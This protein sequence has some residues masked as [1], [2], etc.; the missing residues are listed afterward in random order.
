MGTY[1]KYFSLEESQREHQFLLLV[2]GSYGNTEV[3]INGSMAALHHY[4]YTEFCA[5]LT[6]WLKFGESEKN[7]L[8]IVVENNA[9]PNSRWYTGSGLYRHVRLLEG[10]SVYL[11]PWAVGIQ[12]PDLQT[13]E[14]SVTLTNALGEQQEKEAAEY[15]VKLSVLD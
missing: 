2:E 15:E 12:T 13:I 14:A 3:W 8:K 9:Q 11:A 10:E 1:E 6:K 5:D 7:K 4:G